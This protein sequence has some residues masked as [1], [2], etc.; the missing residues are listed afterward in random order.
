MVAQR[1]EKAYEK[2]AWILLFAPG[3][4]AFIVAITFLLSGFGIIGF[5][6]PDLLKN[7]GVTWNEVV[8]GSPGLANV[9]LTLLILVGIFFV[10][11]TTFVMVIS[12]VSYRRG[13]RWA[14]YALWYFPIV[15]AYLASIALSHGAATGILLSTPLLIMSLLGL[16]LPYRK[17]FPKV[18]AT[19]R[20]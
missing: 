11:F 1:A 12:R 5:A 7:N 19:G 6:D 9:I 2:H 13:E 17:F 15:T 14:W 3:F 4:V 10:G 8:A 20:A 16:L 18:S